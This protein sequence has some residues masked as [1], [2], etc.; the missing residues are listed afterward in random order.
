[1]QLCII[2]TKIDDLSSLLDIGEL[3]FSK[4]DYDLFKEQENGEVFVIE[5]NDNPNI[6]H[7]IEDSIYGDDIYRNITNHLISKI[8]E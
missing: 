2:L 6:D 3:S 5:I 7:R 8:E 4:H 1:M